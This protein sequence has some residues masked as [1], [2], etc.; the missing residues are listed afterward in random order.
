MTLSFPTYIS[1]FIY[2]LFDWLNVYFAT[3]CRPAKMMRHKEESVYAPRSLFDRPSPALMKMR[4]DMKLYK[5]RAIVRPPMPV[6]KTSSHF[7]KTSP[8]PDQAMDWLVYEEWGLLNSIQSYQSL[9]LSTIILSPG[10]TPNWDMVAD[11]INNGARLFRSPKH[12]RGRYESVIMPREEGKLLYDTTPKKQKKQKG[13]VY[14]ALPMSEVRSSVTSTNTPRNA[15]SIKYLYTFVISCKDYLYCNFILNIFC[16]S[17]LK[18][19]GI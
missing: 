17:S 12:C 3:G 11:S 4:R 18:N 7:V 1:I 8:E 13:S 16:V 10:H 9:P 2:L 14:K 6:L 15:Y 5:Y 19:N